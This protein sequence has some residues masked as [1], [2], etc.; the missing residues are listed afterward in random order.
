MP[1]AVYQIAKQP[2]GNKGYYLSKLHDRFILPDV[3]YGN[4]ESL[5]IR[6]WNTFII[7]KTSTGILLTGESGSGKSL[8]A[9][10]ISNLAIS[11]GVPVVYIT[12]IKIQPELVDFLKS[13]SNVVIYMD[14]F[15]KCTDYNTQ[16][17]ML[18]FF[19]DT[20]CRRLYVITENSQYEINKF[21]RNRPGRIR[22]HIDYK[23][24]PKDIAVDYLKKNVED[25]K[26]REEIY[27]LYTV[28][29]VFSFDHLQAICSEH[30]RY[31]NDTIDDLIRILNLGI[32]AKPY[33][34][35]VEKAFDN[36]SKT[37]ILDEDISYNKNADFDNM[38][39]TFRGV[40]FSIYLPIE[41]FEGGLPDFTSYRKNKEGEITHAAY[42]F[43]TNVEKCT[44]KDERYI[45]KNDLVTVYFIRWRDDVLS[46]SNDIDLSP[47][48]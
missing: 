27:R 3:L 26:F 20:V 24:I 11:K 9:E 10:V 19:S 31:P 6:V 18:S 16:N 45:F 12:S 1:P 25:L 40:T 2:G 4:I 48:E 21:I 8:L 42:T 13:L 23:K 33:V 47:Y 32:L 7:G 17:K 29:K 37:R 30:N 28:S 36:V 35:R 38:F 41:R 44:Y 46:G 39:D 15:G 43:T 22:Y 14:E 5:A 34:V